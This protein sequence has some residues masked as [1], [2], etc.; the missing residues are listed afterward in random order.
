MPDS[1]T[2]K[3]TGLAELD[4]ALHELPLKASRRIVRQEASAAAA[5]WA[6]EMRAIVRRGPHH[7]AG[8]QVDFGLLAANIIEKTTVHNDLSASVKVGPAKKAGNYLL[9]WAVILEF[10]RAAG[11][12]RGRHYPAM[13][14]YP[15]VRPAYESM[16]GEVLDRYVSGIRDALTAAGLKVS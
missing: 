12:K 15:F 1:V 5:A 6:D 2:V 3:I 4:R 13:P 11:T 7:R 10:G 8:G 16:K 14:P 9:F